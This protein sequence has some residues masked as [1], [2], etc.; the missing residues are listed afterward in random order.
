MAAVGVERQYT[1][2][3]LKQLL[4]EDKP[5][6]AGVLEKFG[7]C[8]D[9][10]LLTTDPYK[11]ERAL[12]TA[13]KNYRETHG[14]KT[15]TEANHLELIKSK[16]TY[17]QGALLLLNLRSF[18]DDAV[19]RASL[20]QTY[21]QAVIE[22]VMGFFHGHLFNDNSF[23][24]KLLQQLLSVMRGLPR[25]YSLGGLPGREAEFKYRMGIIARG[26]DPSIPADD[27]AEVDLV[28]GHGVPEAADTSRVLAAGGAGRGVYETLGVMGGAALGSGVSGGSGITAGVEMSDLSG[29]TGA[30]RSALQQQAGHT[31]NTRGRD[32]T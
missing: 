31:E 28:V 16:R 1:L 27:A 3:E 14:N 25:K 18:A 8:F 7:A 29:T 12:A 21:T 2:A 20:I 32:N 17:A 19:M 9:K 26:L 6:G 23:N 11:L 13:M 22:N 24:H 15:D 4:S 10:N 30:A 5:D